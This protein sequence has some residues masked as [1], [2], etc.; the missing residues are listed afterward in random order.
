MQAPL[1]SRLAASRSMSSKLLT[2]LR[3]RSAVSKG[4]LRDGVEGTSS[5]KTDIPLAP[6]HDRPL[7]VNEKC[8]LMILVYHVLTLAGNHWV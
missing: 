3:N 8:L 2:R 4:R 6:A 7:R 5:E 1:H